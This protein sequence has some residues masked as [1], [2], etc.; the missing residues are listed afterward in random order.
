MNIDT[1]KIAINLTLIWKGILKN[2]SGNKK[3]IK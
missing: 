3:E 1:G 2:I